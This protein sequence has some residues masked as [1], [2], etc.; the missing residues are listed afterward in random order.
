MR[1]WWRIRLWIVCALC[2]LILLATGVAAER[3]C[4]SLGKLSL[5]IDGNRREAVVVA[6]AFFC[7]G[8][9]V[10]AHDVLSLTFARLGLEPEFRPVPAYYADTDIAFSRRE[11]LFIAYPMAAAFALVGLWTWVSALG[12]AAA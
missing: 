4:Q 1:D 10:I 5:S 6:A 9:G 12:C 8:F 3:L 11:R 7:F 2:A